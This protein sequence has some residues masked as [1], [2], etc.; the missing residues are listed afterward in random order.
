VS[1]GGAAEPSYL[2]GQ[3]LEEGSVCLLLQWPFGTASTELGECVIDPLVTL[4][5][6]SRMICGL[7]SA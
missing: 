4:K 6:Q 3:A 2:P 1:L 7:K 5:S